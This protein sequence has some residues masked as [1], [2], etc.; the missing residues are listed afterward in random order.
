MLP[1]PS[2]APAPRRN[3]LRQVY[4][5]IR[6][7]L[8]PRAVVAAV[9]GY[10]KF[11]SQLAQYRR[12]AALPPDTEFH[13]YPMLG[14]DT[15]TTGFDA[16]YLRMGDWAL[17]RVLANPA[18]AHVDV[19]SQLHWVV[20]VAASKPITFIDIRPA[21]MG[22]AGVSSKSGSL[23]ALPYADRE[24]ASLSCLHVVEHIGLGR[25]GDPLDPEGTHKSVRELARVLA[26]GGTLLLATP[27]G[28]PQLWF[29][30]HRVH[31]PSQIIAW[32]R[33]EGLGLRSFAA[34][35]DAG[36]YLLQA[37]PQDY[38]SARYACGMFEFVR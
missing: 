17:R 23:M 20:S 6:P 19:G 25:Y 9:R 34:V 12:M 26:P 15:S 27:V 7:A 2:P 29:N 5:Y 30:A 13:L 11:F 14:E 3:A 24:V 8:D 37:D 38:E 22:I 4:R 33:A 21:E 35:D 32:C 16:H 36:N 28:Q 10:P 1:T 31:R 18:P